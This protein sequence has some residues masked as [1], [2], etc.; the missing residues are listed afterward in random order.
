MVLEIRASVDGEPSPFPDE[1]GGNVLGRPLA[2]SAAPNPGRGPTRVDSI[3][4]YGLGDG[5]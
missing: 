5:L 4:A 1:N 2:A 3:V